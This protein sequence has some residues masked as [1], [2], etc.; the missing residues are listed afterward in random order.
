VSTGGPAGG[1]RLNYGDYNVTRG[2]FP[3]V[4]RFRQNK[5]TLRNDLTY[6]AGAHVLKGGVITEF[7]RYDLDKRNSEYPIFDFNPQG[8]GDPPGLGVDVPYRATLEIGSGLVREDNAQL[9]AYVQDDWTVAR[10]LTLNLG[11]RWDVETNGLNNRFRTPQVIRDSVSRFVQQYPYFDAQRYFNDGPSDRRRFL[12]AFQ[13]RVGFSYDVEGNGRT[14]VF[15]GGGI[16]YDRVFADIL[17]D[18]R[19]RV[20]RPRYTFFFRRPG[21]AGGA[22]TIPFSPS[23]YSREALVGLVQSGEAGKPEAFLVPDDLQP[24]RSDQASLGIR[25]ER[26]GYQFSLTGTAVNGTNGF[27]YVWGNREVRPGTQY[28]TFRDVPGFATILRAT[29]AGRSWY[30]ALLVQASRPLNE[31]RR[32]GGDLSYTLAKTETNT[33]N[34]DDAFALDY[35]SEAE[36]GRIRSPF[37]ERHRVVLNLVTRAPW[38]IR[39]STVTTLGSGLPYLT[40]TNCDETQAQLQQKLAATPND[41]RLQFCQSR[42]FF[43]NGNGRDFDDNPTGRGGVWGTQPPGR[44]FGPFGKWAFRQ[45]DLRL[46]K[47]VAIPRGQRASVSVDVYN[48]FNFNNFNYEQFGYGLF[49]DR[50]R[51]P[52]PFRTYDARRA[53]LGVRY[54][55]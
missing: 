5:Y 47:D 22:N 41:A 19:L 34:G 55:L 7:L 48:V 36:F 20:Q 13:P 23:Y 1:V 28:G 52:L 46:Q 40:S 35:V 26:N 38:G 15:G 14:L 50:N 6:S 32:W 10:R 24:P 18:E 9:G 25:H 17:I 43:G 3:S 8:V 16:Y 33:R 29:D 11:V 12:R 45:L 37:D 53:Q 2:V 49:N 54:S 27:R 4:Q 42:G 39:A 44:W 31:R 21:T 51:Q 30:R